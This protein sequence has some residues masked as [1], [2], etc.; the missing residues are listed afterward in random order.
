MAT[1]ALLAWAAAASAPAS[2]NVRAHNTT[3]FKVALLQLP[4]GTS[5]AAPPLPGSSAPTPVLYPLGCAP[6]T[7]RVHRGCASRNDDSDYVLAL[8]P[9]PVA[10]ELF[11]APHGEL[12]PRPA[13][14]GQN[15]SLQLAFDSRLCDLLG[16]CIVATVVLLLCSAVHERGAWRKSGLSCSF[17]LLLLLQGAAWL[18]PAAEAARIDNAVTIPFDNAGQHNAFATDAAPREVLRLGP[19]SGQLTEE[20]HRGDVKGEPGGALGVRSSDDWTDAVSVGADT[21]RPLLMTH[22]KGS[23][24]LVTVRTLRQAAPAR[25]RH[26]ASARDYDYDAVQSTAARATTASLPPSMHHNSFPS[27]PVQAPPPSGLPRT[28]LELA[29]ND[30]ALV[31]LSVR[32]L[33]TTTVSPG[34]GTLQAALDA[35]SAGDILE[36]ADGTYTGTSQLAISKDITI[37]A[38]N[39][40]QAII[41]GENARR[42]IYISSGTVVLQGLGVTRGYVRRRH[43]TR[44]QALS[45]CLRR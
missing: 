18:L 8:C 31:H 4:H 29:G 39:S 12:V 24:A 33:A 9:R 10:G 30:A 23:G 3:D 20:A 27:H 17:M 6:F 38:Q 13:Q 5:R 34:A 16:L 35:A 36:L 43:R 37:R 22:D 15:R 1:V 45:H 25:A 44:H 41:D 2:G 32:R 42:G 7:C 28:K 11:A 19:A 26:P 21:I 40:G 14:D